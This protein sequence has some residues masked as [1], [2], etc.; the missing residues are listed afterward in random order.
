MPFP[1]VVNKTDL[2]LVKTAESP[3]PG[4]GAQGLSGPFRPFDGMPQITARS[5]LSDSF[6]SGQRRLL[7][8]VNGQGVLAGYHS[9]A[10][11]IWFWVWFC[12]FLALER[13]T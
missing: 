2:G 7:F 10:Q 4:P 8:S 13:P 1:Q 3:T 5:V 12:L 9:L 11:D 6:A